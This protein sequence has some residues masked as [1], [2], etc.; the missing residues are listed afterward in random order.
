M[1]TIITTIIIIINKYKEIRFLLLTAL[2]KV[3]KE[4]SSGLQ[5]PM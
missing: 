5:I 4:M 2:G 1:I 3:E